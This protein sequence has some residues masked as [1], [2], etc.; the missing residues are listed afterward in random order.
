MPGWIWGLIFSSLVERYPTF[1]LLLA[2]LVACIVWP[3]FWV[4]VAIIF[5]V[6]IVQTAAECR[7]QSERLKA[8]TPHDID[9]VKTAPLLVEKAL[10]ALVLLR[11][12]SYPR[13]TPAL[14]E[15]LAENA[16]AWSPRAQRR[17]YCPPDAFKGI[18]SEFN[19]KITLDGARQAVLETFGLHAELKSL[20]R[21]APVHEEQSGGKSTLWLLG[22]TPDLA[23]P[24]CAE[25]PKLRVDYGGVIERTPSHVALKGFVPHPWFKDA[26]PALLTL[27]AVPDKG[28]PF[29]WAL[30]SISL[31]ADFWPP[32]FSA[33]EAGLT[34]EKARQL[35]ER[36]LQAAVKAGQPNYRTLSDEVLDMAAM[37][38]AAWSPSALRRAEHAA[39]VFDGVPE[40]FDAKISLEDARRAVRECLGRRPALNSP[41][42]LGP[43]QVEGEGPKQKVWI[44]GKTAAPRTAHCR[45]ELLRLVPEGRTVF[46]EGRLANPAL[47]SEDRGR[48]WID[49]L[50]D[51]ESPFGYVFESLSIRMPED[52]VETQALPPP[53]PRLASQDAAAGSA[54]AGRSGCAA[55]DSGSAAGEQTGQ[56]G[57]GAS[58]SEEAI[59]GRLLAIFRAKTARLGAGASRQSSASI[60]QA[61]DDA[62]LA[63]LP[64]RFVARAACGK[65]SL[66]E[67]ERLVDAILAE[68]GLVPG[69]AD[70][71]AQ[72]STGREAPPPQTRQANA[73]SKL[74]TAKGAKAAKAAKATKA[75]KAA[76]VGRMPLRRPRNEDDVCD[77]LFDIFEARTAKPL[78]DASGKAAGQD[79]GGDLVAF[80]DRVPQEFIDHALRWETTQEEYERFVDGII[81]GM[82][83]RDTGGADPKAVKARLEREEAEGLPDAQVQVPSR[84]GRLPN[85][86]PRSEDEVCDMLFEVF[87]AKTARPLRDASGKAAG[88]DSGGDVAAFIDRVPQEFIDHALR[89]ETTLEEYED[90]VDRIIAEMA[91]KDTGGAKP[92]NRPALQEGAEL[93]AKVEDEPVQPA[94]HAKPAKPRRGAALGAKPAGLPRKLIQHLLAHALDAAMATGLTHFDRLTDEMLDQTALDSACWS[95]LAERRSALFP[96]RFAG[97]PDAFDARISV[98]DARRAA[99]DCFG[100]AASLASLPE[101]S[102]VFAPQAGEAACRK[103]CG[104][105]ILGQWRG[106]GGHGLRVRTGTVES[107]G[108][109][110]A[111]AGEVLDAKG[112]KR[113]E[114]RVLVRPDASSPFG[115]VIESL[116]LDQPAAC[117]SP[118]ARS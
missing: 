19:A 42:K 68:M 8:A 96:A 63:R 87:E 51:A 27:S 16:A 106:W 47:S 78:R 89:W 23:D 54:G 85:R 52:F 116:H 53:A 88:Q 65:A 34:Q 99:C 3:W 71:E 107:L 84:R 86:R 115:F 15:S 43:V 4:V 38:A 61:S 102:R 101:D 22:R 24:A 28:S 18:A 105:W 97:V 10:Q 32:R 76:K 117:Q 73:A 113:G 79:S 13:I 95:S 83:P 36:A 59:A 74:K 2:C 56:A 118:P 81:S 82:D 60:G 39:F 40:R 37:H 111:M 72:A 46:L 108:K 12:G 70:P 75:A 6:A 21:Y 80:I 67:G 20:S 49:V 91:P 25:L 58:L 48:I 11:A 17:E 90:L 5:V 30:R 114:L 103:A 112:Q 77:I 66:E 1:F 29:G 45:I 94:K 14:I 50:P 41:E 44:L 7:K 104:A 55:P 26:K 9:T 109:L 33:P 64:R 31:E 69:K 57:P 92:A 110:S 35:L 100:K 98:E 62:F 93:Q